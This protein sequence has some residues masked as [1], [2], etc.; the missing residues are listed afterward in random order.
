MIVDPPGVPAV[1]TVLPLLVT[2]VGVIDDNMRLPGST[3]LASAP[4]SP[5]MLGVPGLAEKS[6][7]SLLRRK[8]APCTTVLAP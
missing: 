2:I 3:L 8:P 6:S 5:N 1:S 4:I 7:I